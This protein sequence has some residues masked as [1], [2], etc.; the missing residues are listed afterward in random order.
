MIHSTCLSLTYFTYHNALQVHP[1]CCRW[2]Y[3][4]L[5]YGWVVFYNLYTHTHAHPTSTLYIHLSVDTDCFQI[6]AIVNSAALN[7]AVH[8]WTKLVL[9]YNDGRSFRSQLPRQLSFSHSFIKHSWV[10][11]CA[12]RNHR[13]L[14]CFSDPNRQKSFHSWNISLIFH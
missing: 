12:W 8:L 1:C 3:F 6:L 4:I 13:H 11:Q 7:T 9:N 14:V 5:F 10:L 2:Q